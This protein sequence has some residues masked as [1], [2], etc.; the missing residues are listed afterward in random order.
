MAPAGF[1]IHQKDEVMRAIID[2]YILYKLADNNYRTTSIY[3]YIY[4]LIFI[5]KMKIKNSIITN[6]CLAIV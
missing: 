3:I 2:L 5:S 6:Q 1:I 4:D